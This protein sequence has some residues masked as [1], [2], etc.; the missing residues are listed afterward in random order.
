MGYRSDVYIA[1]TKTR[2]KDMIAEALCSD[3]DGLENLFVHADK[4]HY[5][6]YSNIIAFEIYDIKW[7]EDYSEVS[8][9]QNFLFDSEDGYSFVRIGEEFEDTEYQSN[10]GYYDEKKWYDVFNIYRKVEVNLS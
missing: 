6:D 7:Y 10:S 9:I 8:F 2:Y 5:D 4:I 3:E 1:M